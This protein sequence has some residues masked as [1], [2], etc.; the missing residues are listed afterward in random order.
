MRI[1]ETEI[2]LSS[3][4]NILKVNVTGFTV[5]RLKEGGYALST[6]KYAFE[7]RELLSL[8]RCTL[9]IQ[10]QTMGRVLRLQ[11]LNYKRQHSALHSLRHTTQGITEELWKRQKKGK[12]QFTTEMALKN[13]FVLSLLLS[14]SAIGNCQPLSKFVCH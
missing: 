9:L 8:I 13:I 11:W 10:Q 14:S 4:M 7:E 5:I 3:A 12:S 2:T 1:W 6:A